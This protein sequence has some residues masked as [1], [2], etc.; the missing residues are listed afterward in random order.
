M[1]EGVCRAG[2]G[3]YD[4]RCASRNRSYASPFFNSQFPQARILH[5]ENVLNYLYFIKINL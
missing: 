4:A 1:L 2:L 3:T 5:V